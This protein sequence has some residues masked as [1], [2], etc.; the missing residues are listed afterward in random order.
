MNNDILL[1][2]VSIIIFFL[3]HS[4]LLDNN[5]DPKHWAEIEDMFLRDAC[6]LLGLSIESPLGKCVNKYVLY[7]LYFIM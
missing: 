5:L 7:L 1:T 4:V 6:A 2:V 3:G